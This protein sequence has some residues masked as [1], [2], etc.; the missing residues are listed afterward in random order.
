MKNFPGSFVRWCPAALVM[1]ASS[2]QAQPEP[3]GFAEIHQL[4]RPVGSR[5]GETVRIVNRFGNVRI[6]AIPDAAEGSLRATIQSTA[7]DI[8]PAAIRVTE[9]DDGPIFE[10]V[11]GKRAEA[12]I[13]VDVVVALPDVAGIDVEMDQGDFTMHPA[14]CPVRIR[15]DS[16]S[17]NL[18]T[19]G[20]VDVKVLDGHVTYNPPRDGKVDGGRIQTSGAPVD[21][22]LSERVVLNFRVLSGVA[23]TTD[24]LPLLRSARRDG[25]AMLFELHEG[26]PW[27]EV[28]TDHGPVRLVLEG[29]R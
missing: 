18:R 6:R 14:S 12:L 11:P 20:P 15:A 21:A 23:V 29:H 5:P 28:L 8:V 13:R 16:G 7:G 26:A 25:R 17:I 2:V 9:S 1:L 3:A 24:S 27:L 10:I 22:L 19:S 4:D